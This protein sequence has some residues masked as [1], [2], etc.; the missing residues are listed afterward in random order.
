MDSILTAKSILDE[1]NWLFFK[2]YKDPSSASDWKS[3]LNWY[4]QTLFDVVKSVVLNTP[5]IRVVFFGF[6]GPQAYAVEEENYEQKIT[7]PNTNVI[8][9]RLRF[10]VK[11]GSK[12]RVKNALIAS[13][14]RNS[15]LVW[16]YEV[17]KTYHVRN[18]LGDRYGSNLDAQTLQFFRYWDAACRYILSIVDVAKNWASDVDVWGVPHLVNNS[19]GA[20]LRPERGP[21]PCPSCQTHMYMS[22]HYK[23]SQPISVQVD[24][25]PYCLFCPNCSKMLFGSFNI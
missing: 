5:Q 25:F 12:G 18:D 1:R 2:L 20:W 23:I 15:N 21:V 13:I 11:R 8:F 22:T 3:N 7:P 4:H 17:M 6:Y 24:G 10:S 19:L 14:N 9:I 16:N